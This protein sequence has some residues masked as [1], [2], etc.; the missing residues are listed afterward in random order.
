MKKILA[1]LAAISLLA[2]TAVGFAQSNSV[3]PWTATEKSDVPGY[4]PS[5]ATEKSDLPGYPASTATEKSDL[6]GYPASTATEKSTETPK[7]N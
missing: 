2:S 5:T 6:P 3:S 7:R 4:P 1:P